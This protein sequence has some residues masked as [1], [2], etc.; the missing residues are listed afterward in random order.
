MVITGKK[1]ITPD[2][3]RDGVITVSV[4]RQLCPLQRL[5]V[6]SNSCCT[7]CVRI[8][9]AAGLNSVIPV[10]GPLQSTQLPSCNNL[11]TQISSPSWWP[12]LLWQLSV[13]PYEP[14]AATQHYRRCGACAIWKSVAN[15][16]VEGLAC[17]SRVVDITFVD[18]T[19][20]LLE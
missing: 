13:R 9:V 5:Q 12:R 4:N 3:Q 15:G 14:F 17:K 1:V 18:A 11:L 7:A 10:A 2:F 6:T 19:D 20:H 16:S 8:P